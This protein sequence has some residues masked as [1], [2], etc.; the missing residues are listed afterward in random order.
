MRQPSFSVELGR[1]QAESS[2]VHIRTGKV[3]PMSS[4]F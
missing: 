2:R 1:P 4:L 3:G